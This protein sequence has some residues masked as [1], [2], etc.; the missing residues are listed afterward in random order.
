MFMLT[1][2]ESGS[3]IF[4]FCDGLH[5]GET[6]FYRFFAYMGLFMF[7]MLSW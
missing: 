5:A 6:G 2:R 1:S 4:V 3:R 7:S